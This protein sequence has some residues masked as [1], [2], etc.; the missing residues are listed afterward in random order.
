MENNDG[1]RGPYERDP[2]SHDMNDMDADQEEKA[3]DIEDYIAS[4]NLIAKDGSCNACD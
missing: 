3:P 1:Q 2:A 4:P